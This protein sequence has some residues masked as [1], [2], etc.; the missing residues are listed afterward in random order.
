MEKLVREVFSG[1]TMVVSSGGEGEEED[2]AAPVALPCFGSDLI[3]KPEVHS[4]STYVV[5]GHMTL[6]QER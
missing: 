4:M 2:E 3:Y 1:F 5:H 6:E